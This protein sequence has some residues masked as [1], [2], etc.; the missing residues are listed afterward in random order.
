MSTPH[1]K[2]EKLQAL[3][4]HPRTAEPVRDTARRM[5][6]RLNDKISATGA[7]TSPRTGG[8]DRRV[9][10]SK[11]E[12]ARHLDV[13]EIAKLIRQDIK[14]ARKV[15][16]QAAKP[17]SVK[18]PDPIGDAPDQIRIAVRIDR[19]SGGC[20]IDIILRDIPDDWGFMIKRDTW[21]GLQDKVRT[22]ALKELAGEL[23]EILDAYNY[24]GSD[25]A[26]DYWDVRYYSSV[27][28]DGGLLL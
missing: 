24:D 9:Y 26:T 22:P 13:A 18:L 10:G 8:G 23:R 3:I 21:T 17:G 20:S 4:D 27:M 2:I 7:G 5:L 11:Y 6:H 12:Q 19:F 1:Q 15:G 14:L 25:I 28:T 16:R